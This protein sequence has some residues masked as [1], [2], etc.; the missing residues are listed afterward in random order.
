MLSGANGLCHQAIKHLLIGSHTIIVSYDHTHGGLCSARA[1]KRV[2]LNEQLWP[3]PLQPVV[4]PQLPHSLHNA[5]RYLHLL[6]YFWV[7]P[8]LLH[9]RVW[10]YHDG[11]PITA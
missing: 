11:D 1:Q 10:L 6:F 8:R 7:L 9:L 2:Y 3:L 5:V 4:I